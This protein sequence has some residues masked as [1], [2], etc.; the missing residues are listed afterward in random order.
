MALSLRRGI[1]NR[2]SLITRAEDKDAQK[3]TSGFKKK[4]NDK[5]TGAEQMKKYERK[6]EE[7]KFYASVLNPP[8]KRPERSEAELNEA[9]EM[10]T[11]YKRRKMQRDRTMHAAEQRWIKLKQLAFEELP[12]NLKDAAQQDDLSELPKHF[13]VAR[14]DP[15]VE[16]ENIFGAAQMPGYRSYI[17]DRGVK[18]FISKPPK[19]I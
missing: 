2:I 15:P 8:I 3:A 5:A 4:K 16:G 9:R 10:T 7:W 14:W 11:L 19:G 12:E 1:L 17:S 13:I 18:P 6:M